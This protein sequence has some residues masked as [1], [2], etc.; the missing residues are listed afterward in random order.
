MTPPSRRNPRPVGALPLVAAAFVVALAVA[1]RPDA[2]AAAESSDPHGRA[3]DISARSL[4]S[5]SPAPNAGALVPDT[6]AQDADWRYEN[7]GTGQTLRAIAAVDHD[8]AWLAGGD[9][10]KDC[11]IGR[12]VNGGEHWQGVFCDAGLRPES[13][14]FVDVNN[15]WIVG[16]GGLILRTFDG[17]LTWV[18]QRAD[19]SEAILNVFAV[20]ANT[21]FAVTR[22]SEILTTTDGGAKWNRRTSGQD[23]GL[24]DSFWFDARNGFAVGS[25]GLIIRSNDGGRKWRVIDAGSDQRLYAV[26]F[27]DPAHGYALGND[28]RFSDNG[29][30][31]WRL[32]MRPGKTMSDIA[33]APGSGTMGWIIGD[34]GL[35]MRT[36]DGQHWVDEGVGLTSRSIRGLAVVDAETVWV[37]GT[38]GILLHRVGPRT[39][40]TA[41]PPPTAT[42]APPTRTPLPP[43][44]TP[45][46]TPLPTAT[47]RGPWV[48]IDPQGVP[49]LVGAPGARP[50]TITYGNFGASSEIS[51]TLTGPVIFTTGKSA[52]SAPVF[53]IGGAG[54]FAVAVKSASLA[55][56]GQPWTMK[57][58]M[59][60]AQTERAGVIAWQARLPRLL[61]RR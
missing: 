30:E 5:A 29:G 22:G 17:G 53:P 45:S 61:I 8:H 42:Y 51:A 55:K 23:Q 34:E 2:P 44:A 6:S 18:R 11:V 37:V 4:D 10:D 52:L 41:P 14:D 7:S 21:A 32:Q 19:T 40:P 49:L 36:T 27:S 1:L 15:G 43:T 59:D 60:D 46:P 38:G 39:P 33:F 50:L 16:R 48:S 56:P 47:P 24:F 58:R 28:L 26:T 54:T 20:D 57:V 31:S 3:L 35:I 12:T 9:G 13:M 25:G